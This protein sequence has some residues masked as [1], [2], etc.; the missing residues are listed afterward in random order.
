[1]TTATLP[2]SIGIAAGTSV[3]RRSRFFFRK[4]NVVGNLL[5]C[6]TDIKKITKEVKPGINFSKFWLLTLSTLR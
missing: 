4:Y 6:L 5:I 1:M 2:N 3:T